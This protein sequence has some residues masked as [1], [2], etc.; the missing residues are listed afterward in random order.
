M[1]LS[2]QDRNCLTAGKSF[3]P[4]HSKQITHLSLRLRRVVPNP[5]NPRNGVSN[6]PYKNPGA[7]NSRGNPVA[8]DPFKVQSGNATAVAYISYQRGTRSLTA[9]NK[10]NQLI[11]LTVVHI[12]EVENWK[13]YHLCCH[14]V[15]KEKMGLHLD[16][17]NW[18]CK[19]CGVPD[20]DILALRINYLCCQ[21]QQSS[22]SP[23]RCLNNP[24]VSLNDNLGL[25][26]S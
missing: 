6:A 14:C 17:F 8:L 9:L 2:C 11:S 13:A 3:L 18:V 23:P 15:D 12:P 10:A 26:S 4:F 21:N 25:P 22:F 1:L 24:L 19:K 16:I 20:V 7:Q 5:N